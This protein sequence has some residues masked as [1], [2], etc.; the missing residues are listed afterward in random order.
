MSV[1]ARINFSTTLML[2]IASMASA[3]DIMLWGRQRATNGGF[4]G[5]RVTAISAGIGH[6]AFRLSD[7]SLHVWGENNAYGV[8]MPP[9]LSDAV[10]VGVGQFHGAALLGRSAAL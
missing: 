8:A 1:T 2:S 3:D 6:T 9:T 7:G 5:G 10:M 4:L